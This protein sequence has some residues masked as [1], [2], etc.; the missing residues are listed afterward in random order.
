MNI[1]IENINGSVTLDKS[2]FIAA[3]G[4]GEIYILPPDKLIKLYHEV[5]LTSIRQEKVLDLCSK[6]ETFRGLFSQTQYAF[7]EIPANR[8][9]IGKEN[10]NEI[11]GFTMNNLGTSHPKLYKLIYKENE[12]QKNKDGLSLTTDTAIAL[13]Y[14]LYECLHKLHTSRIILGDLN[15]LNILYNFNTHKPCFVDI[16]SAQIGK[17]SC[18]AKSDNYLDPLVEENGMN[19]DNV[20][21]YST[22]SDYY[23]M[24]VIVYELFVGQRPFSYRTTPGMY[25]N[26]R[27]LKRLALIGQMKDQNFLL[28]WV[29]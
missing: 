26:D 6:Y 2:N 19:S 21:K 16:D 25:E 18:L 8:I 13:I 23:S 5:E 28:L 24:A 20:Y 29:V 10:N 4:E 15:P 3:G 9:N 12:F 7:P 11:V 1:R 27:R 14:D 17:Y 22:T